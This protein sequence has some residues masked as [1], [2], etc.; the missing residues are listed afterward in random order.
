METKKIR[1]EGKTW[2]IHFGLVRP[3]EAL[4]LN[5]NKSIPQEMET[6]ED[7]NY[8]FVQFDFYAPPSVAAEAL[9]LGKISKNIRKKIFTVKAGESKY[10][11]VFDD[12]G[13]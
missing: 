2:E 8:N 13:V 10:K 4:Q 9:K 3:I 7:R 6:L 1:K 5:V 11:A 12:H